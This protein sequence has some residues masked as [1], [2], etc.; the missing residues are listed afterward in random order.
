MV[1]SESDRHELY[2]RLEQAIGKRSTETM[3][4][5]LPPV[6]WAE[7]ATKHDLHEL[8][9]RLDAKLGGFDA[10]LGAFDAKLEAM[11]SRI[12]E[13][14]IRTAL[15]VNIPTILASFALAFTAVRLG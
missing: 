15:V 14:I 9:A 12:N 6:G 13:R 8:E 1:V 7:V 5:L 4:S 10:K 11:E 3:M 2:E